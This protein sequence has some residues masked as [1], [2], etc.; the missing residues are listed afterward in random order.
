MLFFYTRKSFGAKPR[1]SVQVLDD[2]IGFSLTPVQDILFFLV[3]KNPGL[4]GVL[5]LL[6]FDFILV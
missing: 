2:R 4:A 5:S 6:L 1:H 3:N